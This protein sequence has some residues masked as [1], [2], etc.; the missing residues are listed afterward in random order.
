MKQV[1]VLDCTMRDGSRT[2]Q[3]LDAFLHGVNSETAEVTVLPLASMDLKPLVNEWFDSRQVLLEE[4]DR[5]NPRFDL[6][7]Q[8]ADADL[9]VAAALYWDY[10]FPA[11]FK[12]Y[13]EN[14]SVDGITFGSGED[15][16]SG[17][18]KAEKFVY[19]TTRGGFA[20]SKSYDDQAYSYL[21]SIRSMLGYGEVI[22][23]AAIGMDVQG[24]DA[25][26]ELNRACQEAE[27][28]AR[29]LTKTS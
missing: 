2:R 9:I 10:S 27:A 25:E 1:L 13:I 15:G 20:K 18:C 5:T 7:H 21:D 29:E 17:L 11:L 16:L 23:V 28:L 22:P 24:F 6:A 4:D 3:L 26:S 12:I 14:I 8:F 19:L